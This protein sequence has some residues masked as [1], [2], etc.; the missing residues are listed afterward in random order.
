MVKNLPYLQETWVLG[1]I[2]GLGR[3]PGEGT[4]TPLQYSGLENSPWDNCRTR[5]SDEHFLSLSHACNPTKLS[6]QLLQW[7]L[8]DARVIT[9]LYIT[10]QPMGQRRPAGLTMGIIAS[11]PGW[12]G[13]KPCLGMERLWGNASPHSEE[14]PS[15]CPLP[16]QAGSEVAAPSLAFLHRCQLQICWPRLLRAEITLGTLFT[17]SAFKYPF[18]VIS[19]YL[20]SEC[21][22]CPVQVSFTQCMLIAYT[23]ALSW[24]FTGP[25]LKACLHAYSLPS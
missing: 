18:S 16:Y 12:T 6:F 4:G 24:A 2:P 14:S 5:M 25:S 7:F 11:S 20:V 8:Q 1:S 13:G 9:S 21:M 3:S 10:L 23:I 15:L 17:I 22:A 19:V